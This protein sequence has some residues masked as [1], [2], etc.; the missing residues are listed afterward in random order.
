[1]TKTLEQ[2]KAELQKQLEDEKKKKQIADDI[3]KL[4]ERL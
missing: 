1:M 4:S 2:L 3:R